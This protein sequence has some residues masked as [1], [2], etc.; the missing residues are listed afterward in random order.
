MWLEI[1]DAA[2]AHRHAVRVCRP[3]SRS[4]PEGA[5]LEAS[6]AVPGRRRPVALPEPDMV[7]ELRVETG[8]NRSL[9]AGR[10]ATLY[11]SNPFALQ[12]DEFVASDHE[13]TN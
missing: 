7:P 8:E 2:T 4:E 13:I 11:E 1:P 3:I 9:A 10:R 5:S 6:L 12:D